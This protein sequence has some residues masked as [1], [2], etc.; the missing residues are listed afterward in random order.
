MRAMTDFRFSADHVYAFHKGI[1]H[2]HGPIVRASFERVECREFRSPAEHCV[3]EDVHD[4]VGS[5]G[6]IEDV[7]VEMRMVPAGQCGPD[8]DDGLDLTVV[9]QLE[10]SAHRVVR[11]ADG[12]NSVDGGVHLLF[13]PASWRG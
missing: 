3:G 7:A 2:G 6:A 9:Q 10:E 11:V 8:V 1:G 12:G 13:C 5:Q 4:V